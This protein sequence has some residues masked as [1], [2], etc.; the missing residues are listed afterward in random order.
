MAEQEAWAYETGE[1]VALTYSYVR[2]GTNE[3]KEETGDDASDDEEEEYAGQRSSLMRDEFLGQ[4]GAHRTIP[5]TGQ[6]C[7]LI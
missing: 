1:L 5:D 6:H 7:C 2:T 4:S 3:K